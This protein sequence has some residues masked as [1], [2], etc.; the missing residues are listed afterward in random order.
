MKLGELI[1]ALGGTL[2]NGSPDLEL[3]GVNSTVRAGERELVFA[4]GLGE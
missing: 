2:A 1:E 3:A 4:G